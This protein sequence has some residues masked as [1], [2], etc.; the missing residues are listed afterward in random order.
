MLSLSSELGSTALS[1]AKGPGFDDIKPAI[2]RSVLDGYVVGGRALPHESVRN[3]VRGLPRPVRPT[4]RARGAAEVTVT[5]FLRRTRDPIS[6][7][8]M[9]D[10]SRVR[11][12]CW[13]PWNGCRSMQVAS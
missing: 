9:L 1:L 4:S 10:V 7:E 3:G 13:L 8:V 12:P 6:L 11:T 2:F 5:R